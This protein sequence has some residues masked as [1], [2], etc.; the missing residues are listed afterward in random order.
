M[1]RCSRLS[2]QGPKDINSTKSGTNGAHMSPCKL[3]GGLEGSGKTTRRKKKI[4]GS[5]L[6]AY[7]SRVGRLGGRR[8]K[9]QKGMYSFFFFLM[10]HFFSWTPFQ[11]IFLPEIEL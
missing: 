2:L 4:T 6:A 3:T 1:R 8:R 10:L 9:G 5:T 11:F 7:V